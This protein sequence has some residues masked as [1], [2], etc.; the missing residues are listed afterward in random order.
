[1]LSRSKVVKRFGVAL[2]ASALMSVVSAQK[3]QVP[4]V[5]DA[6]PHRMPTPA[7]MEREMKRAREV[8]N[9]DQKEGI[10]WAVRRAT[11]GPLAG[12]KGAN[13]MP[14]QPGLPDAS[15][16][17]GGKGVDVAKLAEQYGAPDSPMQ[18]ADPV[19]KL[20]AFVSLS[21]PEGSLKKLG[22]DLK[23]AGGVMI[24]RGT[25][26]GIGSEEWGKSIEALKPIVETGVQLEINPALFKQFQI[27]T[28]PT[29][30]VSPKGIASQGCQ[31]E[32]CTAGNIGIIRGDVSLDYALDKLADRQDEV[33]RFAEKL[34][35]KVEM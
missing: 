7:D 31:E 29:I 8:V 12:Q 23:K 26:Y 10:D 25:K 2:C 9:K 11:M 6:E 19:Y 3:P 35:K 22:R 16:L 17:M 34:Y 28:V 33:G 24:V 21:M 27:K 1:M 13:G 18:G 14:S 32:A 15:K 5:E 20:V 30:V 4:K